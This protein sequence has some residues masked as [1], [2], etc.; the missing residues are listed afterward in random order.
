MDD[1][2]ALPAGQTEDKFNTIFKRLVSG[3][4]DLV[5][6]VAYGI[7]KQEKRDWIIRFQTEKGRRPNEA[8]VWA[9]NEH[10]SETALARLR[11]EAESML[12]AFAESVVES[13]TPD[14]AKGI[15][16]S[17]MEDL[18]KA[19]EQST[20][21]VKGYVKAQTSPGW[22]IVWNTVA[23]LISVVITVAVAGSLLLPSIVD[24]LAEKLAN[25]APPTAEQ[26]AR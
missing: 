4:D 17:G 19:I 18:S 20:T 8:E 6:M 16:A 2:G 10:F 13:R 3:P 9:F 5:G 11:S 7:Y 24:R 12:I 26:T 14:I 25:K 22:A 1:Q 23:W 15:M 21:D